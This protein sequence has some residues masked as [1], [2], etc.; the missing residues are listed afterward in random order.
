[1]EIPSNSIASVI[2]NNGSR[3]KSIE[4]EVGVKLNIMKDSS[5]VRITS[6]DNQAVERAKELIKNAINLNQVSTLNVDEHA[7]KKII[8]KSGATIKALELEHDVNIDVNRYESRVIVRGSSANISKAKDAITQLVQVTKVVPISAEIVTEEERKGE[9]TP[10]LVNLASSIGVTKKSDK[11]QRRRARRR[12][13]SQK[14]SSDNQISH[15]NQELSATPPN[16]PDISS[17]DALLFSN[18]PSFSSATATKITYQPS[19][20]VSTSGYALRL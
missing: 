5:E 8:G 3:I 19:Y 6:S 11:N 7:I 18:P 15:Q 1:M 20:Y 12:I 10:K 2:G 17:I 9:I 13:S 4:N 16:L 14:A